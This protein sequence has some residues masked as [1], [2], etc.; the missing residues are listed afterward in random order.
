M[1]ATCVVTVFLSSAQA[2][3]SSCAVVQYYSLGVGGGLY[4]YNMEEDAVSK[5]LCACLTGTVARKSADNFYNEFL[6]THT[7]V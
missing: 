4:V 7:H 6:L 1:V 3:E 5:K 2:L